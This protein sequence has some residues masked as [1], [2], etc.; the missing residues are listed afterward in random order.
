LHQRA[1]KKLGWRVIVI[2]ECETN[3]EMFRCIAKQLQ[4]TPPADAPAPSN[5]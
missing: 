5:P 3:E 2:W 1:L 4:L